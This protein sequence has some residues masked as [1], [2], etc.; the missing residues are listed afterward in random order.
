MRDEVAA[1]AIKLFAEHG[2]DSVTTAQIAAEAGISPRSFFRYFPTKED[3]VLGSLTDSGTRVRDALAARPV[4]ESAWV[5]LGQAM[6]VLIDRPVYPSEDLEVIARIILETP[7][8]RARDQEK[9]QQWEDLL[10]PGVAQ[11]LGSTRDSSVVGVDDRARA[12]VGAACACL[13]ISTERWLR[14]TGAEDPAL[15]FDELLLSLRT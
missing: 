14:S 10:A 2:F 8:I 4:D 5:A 7:S 13:R 6:H 3:V 12:M 1:V 11:R 9:Y 15:I